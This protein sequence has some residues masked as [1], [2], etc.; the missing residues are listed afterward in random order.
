MPIITVACNVGK[1]SKVITGAK[2]KR[3]RQTSLVAF[4]KKPKEADSEI[5]VENEKDT[6]IISDNS[7]SEM[8]HDPVSIHSADSLADDSICR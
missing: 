1:G 8:N 3:Q 4:V 2:M 7:D 6:D 5:P